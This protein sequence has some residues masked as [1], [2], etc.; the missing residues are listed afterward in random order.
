MPKRSYEEDAYRYCDR[1]HFFLYNQ[2]VFDDHQGE[3]VCSLCGR[4]NTITY[5]GMET[6]SWEGFLNKVIERGDSEY[7]DTR[8]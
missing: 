1:Y 8:Y 3:W 6:Y 2:E 4:T 5:D 7:L